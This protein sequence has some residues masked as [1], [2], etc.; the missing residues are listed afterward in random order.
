MICF[1]QLGGYVLNNSNL[2]WCF[3]SFKIRFP[4]DTCRLNVGFNTPIKYVAGFFF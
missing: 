3:K 1:L 2:K 4:A